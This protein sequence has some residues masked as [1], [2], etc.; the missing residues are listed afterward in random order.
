MWSCSWQSHFS[1]AGFCFPLPALQ[2]LAS[3]S[4]PPSASSGVCLSWALNTSC[5]SYWSPRHTLSFCLFPLLWYL[6][7]YHIHFNSSDGSYILPCASWTD[8]WVN[9]TIQDC[10]ST[11]IVTGECE[12]RT[13]GAIFYVLS[14]SP[15]FFFSQTPLWCPGLC[16]YPLVVY[17]RWQILPGPGLTL[18]ASCRATQVLWHRISWE[19]LSIQAHTVW[20]WGGGL[21]RPGGLSF[22]KKGQ[23]WTGRCFPYFDPR[24]PILYKLPQKPTQDQVTDT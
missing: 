24:V 8:K 2:T 20:Q 18:T 6:K 15:F 17:H 12:L 19:P 1:P 4:A 23:E 3:L 9:G 21:W 10:H 22:S 14:T 5:I 16:K 7:C 13:F 11:L